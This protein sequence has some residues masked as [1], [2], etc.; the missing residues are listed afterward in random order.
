MRSTCL[1]SGP[2]RALHS[3]SVSI[4]PASILLSAAFDSS[5][6]HSS[7]VLTS[8]PLKAELVIETAAP[9]GDG[10]FG[11]AVELA[12]GATLA[13]FR[14]ES[15]VEARTGAT[16]DPTTLSC[17]RK[18]SDIVDVNSDG[19]GECFAASGEGEGLRRAAASVVCPAT[20]TPD[21]T[22]VATLTARFGSCLTE[23]SESPTSTPVAKLADVATAAKR[24]GGDDFA[25]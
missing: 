18:D 4:S 14:A 6:T 20:G 19:A 15:K 12:A 5:S 24:G 7:A 8:T 1:P 22:I 16:T 21:E 13:F 3:S 23:L 11:S 10:G 9:G 17:E 25:K 2:S